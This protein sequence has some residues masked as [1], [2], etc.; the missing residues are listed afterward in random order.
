MKENVRIR[1]M[2]CNVYV[3]Q[4]VYYDNKTNIDVDYVKMIITHLLV[5]IMTV[6]VPFSI[7]TSR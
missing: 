5:S 3:F 7:P 6:L 1:I 4:L 2:T